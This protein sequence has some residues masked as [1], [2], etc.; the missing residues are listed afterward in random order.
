MDFLSK[1][2]NHYVATYSASPHALLEEIR[3][4]TEAHVPMPRMLSG[5]LQGRF[6]ALLSKLI[7]PTYVLEIG[8]YTGYASLCLAEGLTKRGK[9]I[10]IDINADLRPIV[11]AF[12]DRSSW[13]EQIIYKIGDAKTL[14]PTLPERFELVFI[15]ADKKNYSLYYDLVIDKVE[16]GGLIVADNVLW[17]GKVLEERKDKDTEALHTFNEKVHKDVRVDN[18]LLPLRDGLMLLQKK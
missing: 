8:T 7:R 1:E 14:L 18:F 2:L 11:Q 4:Y 17:S 13:K 15:D 9:L 3:S 6:L 5:H 16:T 10:T 12:F